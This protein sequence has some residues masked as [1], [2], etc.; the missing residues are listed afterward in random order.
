MRP[1]IR[2]PFVPRYVT[3]QNKPSPVPPPQGVFGSIRSIQFTDQDEAL[4]KRAYATQN[5]P[6]PIP[7]GV[8]DNF[9]WNKGLNP[10]SLLDNISQAPPNRISP[11]AQGVF[12]N[13]RSIQFTDQDDALLKRAYATQNRPPPIPEGV[14]DNVRW[15]KGPNPALLDNISQAPPNRSPPVLQGVFGNIRS[16]RF[17]DQDEALLER[18]YATQ[19]R[20]PPIPE[21]ILDNIR[22]NKRTRPILPDE[23]RV[24]QVVWPQQAAQMPAAPNGSPFL[25]SSL[26]STSHDVSPLASSIHGQ[27]DEEMENIWDQMEIDPPEFL[28]CRHLILPE[29]MDVDS[30]VLPLIF[31]PTLL[32]IDEP[33]NVDQ[34]LDTALVA[35]LEELLLSD[36]A[37]SIT[38]MD[39][40]HDDP[41]VNPTPENRDDQPLVLYNQDQNLIHPK[42]TE[43]DITPPNLPDP[44]V[45]LTGLV[46]DCCDL[47]PEIEQLAECFRLLDVRDD[48]DAPERV[49]ACTSIPT[50]PVPS[51]GSSD[52]A[53][54]K[55][56]YVPN[57]DWPE[58]I[59]PPSFLLSYTDLLAE[60]RA[61]KLKASS[62]DNVAAE[63]SV[64]NS[65]F[66]ETTIETSVS[67]S[68]P[69]TDNTLIDATSAGSLLPASPCLENPCA[70]P[71]FHKIRA[72]T[73]FSGISNAISPHS[74]LP[75]TCRLENPENICCR[76]PWFIEHQPN[77]NDST[78]S[79]DHP[80]SR[81]DILHASSP[82]RII[83][84][85]PKKIEETNKIIPHT[86]DRR[87]SGLYPTRSRRTHP[88][89]IHCRR[90]RL[91][92]ADWES[93]MTITTQTDD[94]I[95]VPT[96]ESLESSRSPSQHLTP[97]AKVESARLLMSN[98]DPVFLG[99]YPV[100]EVENS[101][102]G[103][104][105]YPKERHPKRWLP[106]MLGVLFGWHW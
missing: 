8:L 22:W 26:L 91:P 74:R 19:N 16:I 4:L 97:S 72:S 42:T 1:H 40:N 51:T 57:F 2:R 82:R 18:A 41:D 10:A 39:L 89:N 62:L 69:E 43:E 47:Q 68:D 23:G 24:P 75:Q 44:P 84:C 61:R 36:E 12:G 73:P 7:E 31:L 21:G 11:V 53:V 101:G 90:P 27:K 104:D 45:D 93:S 33:L 56:S 35:A 76:R 98:D 54:H 102:C 13:I 28:A 95:E 71:A 99:A 60:C 66:D 88:E 5:R 20:P 17:T 86:P 38:D 50:T 77:F 15:N 34:P 6:P 58:P 52:D 80:T 49:D 65:E 103:P 14:L 100:D 9:R 67:F 83:S 25:V 64:T 106:W 3:T 29:S 105:K 55:I 46:N 32:D 37:K 70:R 92:M 48:V 96:S 85:T 63:S 81:I 30:A 78:T 59:L 94:S 79:T 87:F